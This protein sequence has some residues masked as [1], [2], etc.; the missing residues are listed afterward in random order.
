MLGYKRDKDDVHKII[1]PTPSKRHKG[2]K[3]GKGRQRRVEKASFLTEADHLNYE[4]PSGM[5][6]RNEDLRVNL[7]PL[8]SQAST[9]G[10]DE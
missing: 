5:S 7:T 6:R 4:A 8:A 2:T 3:K 10:A 9:I 1:P